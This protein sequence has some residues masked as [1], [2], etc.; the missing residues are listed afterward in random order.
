MFLDGGDDPL[1]LRERR[2][3]DGQLPDAG[4]PEPGA[5]NAMDLISDGVAEVGPLE[6]VAHVA[7]IEARMQAHSNAVRLHDRRPEIRRDKTRPR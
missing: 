7:S 6:R 1:L 2:N 4:H 5:P 3:R